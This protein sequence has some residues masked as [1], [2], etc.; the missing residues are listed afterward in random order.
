MNEAGAP[1]I[2]LIA[3][4][5][6]NRE[7]GSGGKLIWT[8]PGDLPRFKAMTMGYPLV[9]GRKTFE[10]IGRPLPGRTNI[11]ISR[12]PDWR[13]EG[14]ETVHSAEAAL[15]AAGTGGTER[16]YVIGGAEIYRLFL[17]RAE[18]LE[19]TL[20]DEEAA[21]ADV[22]FPDYSG[23]GFL[24]VSRQPGSVEGLVHEFVSL[25]RKPIKT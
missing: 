4:L 21:D 3:V 15:K 7:L 22:F 14:V 9:M 1:E 19:L 11:V 16:M 13:A 23:L 5:G 17:A 6:R 25:E 18:R 10:S 20:V 8:I 2:V 12:N 24:P